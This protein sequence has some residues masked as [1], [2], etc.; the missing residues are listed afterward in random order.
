MYV[1]ECVCAASCIVVVSKI[2]RLVVRRRARNIFKCRCLRVCVTTA[3][4]TI[5][6]KKKLTTKRDDEDR[7]SFVCVIYFCWLSLALRA[8]FNLTNDVSTT[9]QASINL[10]WPAARKI[11]RRL[12]YT[13]LIYKC[14]CSHRCH[15]SGQRHYLYCKKRKTYFFLYFYTIVCVMIYIHI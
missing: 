12:H 9:I 15:R 11:R 3:T 10:A 7:M 8:I 13:T 6:K 14:I 2:K 4:T 1:F 5:K